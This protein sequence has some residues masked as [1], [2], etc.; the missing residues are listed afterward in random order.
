MSTQVITRKQSGHKFAEFDL[1]KA[2]AVLGLPAVHLMEEGIEADIVSNGVLNLEIAI[3]ALSIVGPSVFM[4]CMGFG[5][6]GTRTSPQS[7][8]RQ[9]LRF[10]SLG[11]I[12]NVLCWLLPGIL[13]VVVLGDPL[14][15]D[16]EYCLMSDIYYFVGFFHIFYAL[17]RKLKINTLGLV[18]V[19]M[20][21]LMIN[22]LLTPFLSSYITDSTLAC[23][24]G[25][26]V[27]VNESSCFPL[28]SWAIFPSVGILL[29]EILKKAETE[30]REKIMKHL[31]IISPVAFVCFLVFLWLNRFD[32]QPCSSTCAQCESAGEPCRR[33]STARPHCHEF[34]HCWLGKD[35]Q[36]W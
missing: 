20:V 5:L 25:N 18:T 4:M 28:M 11:S 21:M 3:V 27:Y 1:L 22:T 14:L 6:G 24:I 32:L 23:V 8:L 7:S 35:F 29:G 19:S 15:D 10:L 36:R 31:L 12:L 2:F 16:I 30:Q 13:Q 9:G 33:W 17:I 26:I 34:H